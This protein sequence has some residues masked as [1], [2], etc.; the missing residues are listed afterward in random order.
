VTFRDQIDDY[1]DLLKQTLDGVDRA[2][3]EA[4]AQ[5]F[6]DAHGRGA[7][8]FVCGNGGSAST[9][10]HMACDLNKGVSYGRSRRLRVHALTDNIAT[11]MAYANDVSYEDV[12]AEQLRN[13]MNDGDVVI[14][15]SGSGNSRNVLNAI[16]YANDRGNATVGITGFDGGKLKQL[17]SRNVNVPV[18]DMQVCEDVHLIL[19]HVLMVVLRDATIE[20]DA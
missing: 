15:I 17:A 11:I 13:F 3:V 9:A 4:L 7:T 19:N 12:F 14:G 16:S 5:V 6:L 10:S 18:D 8:V 2:D 1:F 20:G